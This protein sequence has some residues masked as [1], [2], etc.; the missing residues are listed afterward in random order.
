M[1]KQRAEPP[2]PMGPRGDFERGPFIFRGPDFQPPQLPQ[3]PRA[4]RDGACDRKSTTLRGVRATVMS[5]EHNR[6]VL[7]SAAGLA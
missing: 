5:P 7:P 2:F 3:P 6:G 4:P 1:F